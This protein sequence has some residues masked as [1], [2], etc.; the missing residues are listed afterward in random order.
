[1]KLS[2]TIRVTLA[3]ARVT[4]LIVTDDIPGQW[5]IKDPIDHAM[6]RYKDKRAV[7]LKRPLERFEVFPPSL[8]DEPW[9]WKYREGL[10]CPYCVAVHAAAWVTVIEE[11]TRH[12]PPTVRRVWELVTGALAVS[13]VAGHAEAYL[14]GSDDDA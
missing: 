13:W 2:D 11:A 9:W 3:T 12:A 5:W 4:R 10:S 6:H 8:F 1:M 7:P 14:S